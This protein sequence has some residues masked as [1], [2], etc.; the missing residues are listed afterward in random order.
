MSALVIEVKCPTCGHAHEV[1]RDGAVW[2][3]KQH[4]RRTTYSWMRCDGGEVSR[5][6]VAEAT[7]A[8]VA[9]AT[10][11]LAGFD[12]ERERRRAECE[13]DLAM[14]DEREKT[15]RSSI[16]AAE[17]LLKRLQG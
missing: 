14:I 1:K 15:Q 2:R 16:A 13:R 8:A 5:E 4:E 11:A 12:G 10:E 3:M 9:K 7:R 6:A 17:R